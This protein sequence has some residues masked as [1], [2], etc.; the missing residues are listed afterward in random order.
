MQGP[1]SKIEFIYKGKIQLI[2]TRGVGKARAKFLKEIDLAVDPDGGDE[3]DNNPSNKE[4][5]GR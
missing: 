5:E 1:P 3:R 4:L 2:S